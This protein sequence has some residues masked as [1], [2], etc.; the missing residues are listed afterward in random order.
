MLL[1]GSEHDAVPF[2]QPHHQKQFFFSEVLLLLNDSPATP[3][4]EIV[5]EAGHS[6]L[7]Q[8]HRMDDSLYLGLLWLTIQK[9]HGHASPVRW[10]KWSLDGAEAKETSD[11]ATKHINYGK[12]I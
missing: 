3:L 7:H 4:V 6:A 5:I 8:P 9:R 12:Y 10:R 11:K 1:E 2:A